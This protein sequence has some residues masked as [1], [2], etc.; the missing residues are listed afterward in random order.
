MPGEV[1]GSWAPLA[2]EYYRSWVLEKLSRLPTGAGL[3]KLLMLQKLG[4]VKAVGAAEAS[5]TV[6]MWQELGAGEAPYPPGVS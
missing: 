2:K 3:G 6:L 4:T 1:A 5:P